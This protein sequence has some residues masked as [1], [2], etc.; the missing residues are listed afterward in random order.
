VRRREFIAALGGVAA[1]ALPLTARA[2][3][4]MPVI[5]VLAAGSPDADAFRVVAMREGLATAGF[6]EGQN[7]AI[8][9]RWA[10]AQYERLPALMA[11]LIGRQVSVIVAINNASASAARAAN[12][13]IPIV[14]E[15]GD[16]PIRMGLVASLARPGGTITGVTFLAGSLAAKQFEV[17]SE[18]ISQ[19]EIIGLIENPNNP[20]VETVRRGV[21]AA[22]NASK[23]KLVVEKTASELDFE[24][25]YASFV[26]QG[27][28][29]VLI[30]SDAL[31]NG[32]PE[33]FVALSARHKL[34][35]IHSLRTFPVAGG[36]LSY[37][38]S[39]TDA[40][41]Q[42]G[43]YAG[44]ILKGEKP[45][46]LPVHQASK[47]ELVVNLK[48]AKAFGLEMPQMLLARADEVIE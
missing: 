14:F 25:A 8:E 37:G 21:Q 3:Q 12:T 13:T 38:T 31:F 44:R 24:T 46:D 41:R 29:A 33:Q 19:A 48:A 30:R 22:A 23:K 5:G 43:I 10:N 26:R 2:Q 7:I 27:V 6:V 17:L 18:A 20:N 40:L 36:L 45:A 39:L 1:A 42:V 32:R 16:D 35:A 9:Y 15:I 11:D 28:G 34:P 47:V 4:A